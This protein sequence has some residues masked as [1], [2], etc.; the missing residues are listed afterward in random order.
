MRF[1]TYSYTNISDVIENAVSSFHTEYYQSTSNTELIGGRWS[2]TIP[3][4]ESGKYY[5]QK[6]ITTFSDSNKAPIE[7]KPVCITGGIGSDG[8]GIK[9][10]IPEYAKNT[11][12]TTA[13]V[14]G[15]SSSRPTWNQGEY[16]WTRFKITY[17]DGSNP[18]YTTPTCD[19]SWEAMNNLEIGGRNLLKSTS[20]ITG[21]KPDQRNW[22][23][24][25]WGTVLTN[26]TDTATD[27]IH[28]VTPGGDIDINSGVSFYVNDIKYQKGENYTFSIAIRG[29][30]NPTDKF[31]AHIWYETATSNKYDSSSTTSWIDNQDGINDGI[32]SVIFQ[33]RFIS[34]T[35]PG[36]F[37]E[38]KNKLRIVISCKKMD[39]LLC[40]PQL[41]KGNKP[42]D[43]KRAE[44][45][46]QEQFTSV[47]KT[48]SGVS[49]KVDTVEGKI[50][51]KVWQT[52]IN[53]AVNNYDGTTVKSIRD[54]I[55]QQEQTLS[56]FKQTVKDMQTT[57]ATKADGNTVETI[58]NNVS[59]LTQDLS[60]FKTTVESTYA[61]NDNLKNNYFTKTE[62]QQLADK[63]YWIVS[64]SSTSSSLTL[65]SQALTAMT[66]QFV[67]KS[68]DGKRVVIQKGQ[69]LLDALKSNNYSAPT[70]ST[71]IYAV[72]GT[73]YDLSNGSI[74][75]KNFVLDSNGNVSLKGTV[76]ATSGSFTGDIVANSLTLGSKVSISS[77]KITGLST[78]ATSGKYTDLTGTP[79]LDVYIQKDG[80]IGS[81]P[82]D[83]VTGFK[84]S[85]TGLLSASNAV[86]YGTIYASE[87]IIGG[88][89]ISGGKLV[90][91][92][93]NITGTLSANHIGAG[94]IT[95]DK[96]TSNNLQGTNGWINLNKGIFNYGNGKL[97]WDGN[98]LS[99]DGSGTF[100]GNITATSGVIGGCSISNGK[101]VV[102]TANIS[103]TLTADKIIVGG[104]GL[105]S[106][107]ND[108][109][110]KVTTAQTTAN[111]AAK[112]AT[113]FI[114]VDGTGIMVADLAKGTG[115]NVFIDSDSVDIRN[116]TSV[117]ASFAGNDI[118]LGQGGQEVSS[119]YLCEDKGRI[120]YWDTGM[121]FDDNPIF[122]DNINEPN[123]LHIISDYYI[124]IQGKGSVLIRSDNDEYM[125]DL[126]TQST[127]LQKDAIAYMSSSTPGTKEDA[128]VS[129]YVATSGSISHVT[130]NARNNSSSTEAVFNHNSLRMSISS[131]D[132]INF[133][134]SYSAIISTDGTNKNYMELKP[135]QVLFPKKIITNDGFQ[136]G[137]CVD[138]FKNN[139]LWNG[140][141]MWPN[142]SQTATFSQAISKQPHGIILVFRG[143]NSGVQNGDWHSFFVSKQEVADHGGQG[144]TFFLSHTPG[145]IFSTKYIYISDGKLVGHDN[146]SKSG[147]GA[148]GVK[149]HNN[150]YVLQYVLGV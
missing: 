93:A 42:T 141:A 15:W 106:Q 50:T 69:I 146:N 45:D 86:I 108:L 132:I 59:S 109:S 54:K 29:T 122:T 14:S 147:T 139:I 26:T 85:S 118:Y 100:S 126:V 94:T 82:G 21:Y 92:T 79:N 127:N 7:T 38:T 98:T 61:T 123:T 70:S 44:E 137:G 110:G 33:R 113:N 60:G 27:S 88:C 73:F 20:S 101:L 34:F 63:I 1:S 142:A 9:S 16:I 32:S 8:R 125:A 143:Y 77:N 36:D 62:T 117:L 140:S 145:T 71:G 49:S 148:D 10:I 4:W 75:S 22:N 53:N 84:V 97:S 13:P 105:D 37:D 90:I 68:P 136:I 128:S 56:G 99:V 24:G 91:P 107:W 51:N 5:W 76:Y 124:K 3:P 64:D 11:N 41:E 23:W 65:T 66:N 121:N 31:V 81:T 35:V 2:T 102:P 72:A 120:Y 115:N 114:K 129:T 80:T 87:G 12:G 103:G 112:T 96:I 19:S 52:D 131:V 130:I 67:V 133:G 111:N 83:G 17:N 144:H 135:T 30:Y 39:I 78:V 40:R 150:R 47:I 74:T 89:Q 95:V 43:W 6:T 138:K 48:L 18:E 46:I 104:S 55:S 119:I 57:I 116:G 28:I 58:K 25:D 149:Y 134:K